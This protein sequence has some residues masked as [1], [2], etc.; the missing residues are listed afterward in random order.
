MTAQRHEAPTTLGFECS[1]GHALHD[2]TVAMDMS[3]Q[4]FCLVCLTEAHK[5][6]DLVT[7]RLVLT[8]LNLAPLPSRKEVGA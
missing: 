3:G 5:T 4:R 1:F 8:L 7:G 6:V 2:G